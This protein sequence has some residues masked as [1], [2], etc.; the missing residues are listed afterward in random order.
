MQSSNVVTSAAISRSNEITS[1]ND[2][3]GTSCAS[4]A[5]W[6]GPIIN[7]ALDQR[8]P[9]DSSYSPEFLAVQNFGHQTHVN[10]NTAS[11]SIPENPVLS[12]SETTDDG[13]FFYPPDPCY[14]PPEV[15]NLNQAYVWSQCGQPLWYI[16]RN[17]PPS[18]Q[19]MT[20]Q[21]STEP[22][23]DMIPPQEQLILPECAWIEN[24][25]RCGQPLLDDMRKLGMHLGDSH[26]IQGN[27]KKPVTC[28][29]EGCN[30]KLQRGAL[31]RHIRSRHLK[32]RWACD[33]CFKT[34]SRRDA[35]RKHTKGCQAAEA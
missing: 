23:P 24:G 18:L 28:F 22:L 4:T 27:D 7:S 16:P 6:S 2:V 29:W 20:L 32:T 3:H 34:Y 15:D 9:D 25:K 26:G 5:W 21:P 8:L 1:P 12:H 19:A 10:D 11:R 13:F 31:A 33:N 30:R 35:M 14:I 17:F